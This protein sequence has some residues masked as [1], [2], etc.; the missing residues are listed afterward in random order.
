M[1]LNP[2]VSSDLTESTG[3]TS[4]STIDSSES[5]N[6]CRQCFGQ[7][8]ACVSQPIPI[9]PLPIPYSRYPLCL[10]SATP[11]PNAP[12]PDKLFHIMPIS[13]IPTSYSTGAYSAYS[14]YLCLFLLSLFHIMHILHILTSFSRMA[15][16]A[17]SYSL[18]LFFLSLF[19]IL[20]FHIPYSA[21]PMPILTILH[22]NFFRAKI[23][24]N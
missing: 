6:G 9:L 12:I 2:L 23:N 3:K 22:G 16:S 19:H 18:C 10:F 17:Y 15:Y 8:S 11:I 24:I 1:T 13:P 20:L 7:M 4:K 21:I 14:Y 5:S